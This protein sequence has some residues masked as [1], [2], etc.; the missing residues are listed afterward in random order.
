M[1]IHCSWQRGVPNTTETVP[2]PKFS[3]SPNKPNL[4][5]EVREELRALI[6]IQYTGEEKCKN[7]LIQ[8]RQEYVLGPPLYLEE[9]QE[10]LGRSHLQDSGLACL[11]QRHNQNSIE[12]F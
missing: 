7:V 8:E 9:D 2:R 1:E 6:E 11:R 12:Y 10:H 5:K 4:Q 3:I